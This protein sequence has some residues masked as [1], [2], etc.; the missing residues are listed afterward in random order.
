[1]TQFNA[2]LITQIVSLYISTTY[3][4][5]RI[6][7]I[8]VKLR[9]TVMRNKISYLLVT[10]FLLGYFVNDVVTN[11]QIKLV[12]EANASVAGMDYYALKNDYDFRRA[13]MTVAEEECRTDIRLKGK[14]KTWFYCGNNSRFR[15]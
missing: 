13:V 11:T 5:V 6:I 12:S 7:L 14:V 15:P 9:G 1:M 10:S 4:H 2:L 8:Q 3:I